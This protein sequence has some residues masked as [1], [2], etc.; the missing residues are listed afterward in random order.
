MS[1][2]LRDPMMPALEKTI[3]KI[4]MDLRRQKESDPALVKALADLVKAF[5]QLSPEEKQ[6]QGDW[7]YETFGDPDYVDK[8]ERDARARSKWNKEEA[9][10][11]RTRLIRRHRA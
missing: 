1:H 6:E 9:E 10:A 11:S 2:S 4:S 8:L 5:A 7:D 3:R